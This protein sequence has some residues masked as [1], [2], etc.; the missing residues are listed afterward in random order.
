MNLSKNVL[1]Y[2]KNSWLEKQEL[3]QSGH[4]HNSFSYLKSTKIY[5]LKMIHLN[6]QNKKETICQGVYINTGS[7]MAFLKK[8]INP[9]WDP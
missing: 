4:I 1:E 3:Q 2:Q 8:S 6:Y 7:P 5:I 9:L